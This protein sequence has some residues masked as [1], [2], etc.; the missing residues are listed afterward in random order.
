MDPLTAPG[1][2]GMS[3]IFYESFWHIVGE[4]VSATVLAMLN[5]GIVPNAINST[6]TSLIPKIKNPKKVS[7]FRHFSLCN[8]FYELIAKVLVNR[9]KLV[10]PHMVSDSQTTFLFSRLIT[11]NVLVAFETL[12]YLKCES[13]GKLSYMALKFNM[14]KTYDR[15]KWKFLEKIIRHLGFFGE[16][17]PLSC[18]ALGQFHMLSFSIE[19]WLDT[20]NQIGRFDKVIPYLHTCSYCVPWVFKAFCIKLNLMG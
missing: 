20:L 9:L 15:I 4:D 3:P 16:I 11:N 7:D 2:Y 5:G 13:Q 17:G 1:P 6:F 10:L 12:H 18:L 8:I 14:S 19:N